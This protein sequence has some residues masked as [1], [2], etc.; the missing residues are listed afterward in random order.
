MGIEIK[1]EKINALDNKRKGKF[2]T[3]SKEAD[4]K[5]FRCG[6]TDHFA[7]SPK[8][9]AKSAEC[10]KCH[11]EGHFASMCRTNVKNYNDN[12]RKINCIGVNQSEDADREEYA[13]VWNNCSVQDSGL[14]DV[15]VGGV[16]CNFLIDSGSTCN[17]V[18]RSCWEKL[19]AKHIKCKLEK[20]A[21]R[22]YAYGPSNPLK[23]AGKFIADIACQGNEVNEVEFIVIEGVGKL[24][25]GKAITWKEN[26]CSVGNLEYWST[27]DNI[28]WN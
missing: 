5:C 2:N 27:V 13:F 18:N 24:L 3:K 23:V 22:I 20:T 15:N 12:K 4:K 7:K 26:C 16:W 19:R 14:I 28:R 1:N 11:R 10:H 17:V 6:R 8:C 25:L 9:P 21:T